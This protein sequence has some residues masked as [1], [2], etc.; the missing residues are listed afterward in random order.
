MKKVAFHNLGC[1]VN[2]YELDGISQMFQ[3]RGY[4]IVEFAQKADIYVINTCTVTNLADHKSRQMLNRAKAQN[5]EAIVVA[6]GCFV[7]NDPKAVLTNDSID[8][9]IGNNH[10]AETVDIVEEY[11]K[12]RKKDK[13]LG[14]KTISDLSSPTC[15]EELPISKTSEHTRAYIKIQDGCDQFCSYCAIPLARGRVRSR[16]RKDIIDETKRLA[17]AGYREVVLTG[18]HISSYGLTDAYNTLASNDGTN[19]A[20]LEIIEEMAGVCGIDRIRLGSLEPRLLT[21]EF[22]NRISA[23]KKVCPHFHISLQSGSDTVLTRMNRHYTTNMVEEKIAKLRVAF[24]HPAITCD[25]IT[26]F[27]GETEEE[28]EETRAFLQKA[29]FYECHV[30]KY[31]R[32]RGTSADKMKGQLTDAVKTKRSKILIEES[33]A[34]KCD[35]TQYYVGKTVSVL[36]ED[37]QKVGGRVGTVGYTPEY[38]RVFMPAT[39]SGDIKEILCFERSFDTIMG[40]FL[41]IDTKQQR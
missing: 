34:R 6:V 13:T 31:S 14:G 26:G 3:K 27:P 38:V 12:S 4:E 30:F 16:D 39:K 10:K 25:V 1:K 36:A 11:I 37:T 8:I 32:R 18:I 24:T 2:S 23:V 19:T 40:S 17:A 15:Y 33:N 28:F 9:A 29:D 7:Q 41:A 21:D 5:P 22:I 20:L 35:F